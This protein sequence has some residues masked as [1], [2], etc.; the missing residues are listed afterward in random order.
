MH[1]HTSHTI[2]NAYVTI[3][4]KEKLTTWERVGM[5]SIQERVSGRDLRKGKWNIL[6]EL[7]YIF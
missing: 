4:T 3:I 2:Y 1:T 7:R 6:L 5:G